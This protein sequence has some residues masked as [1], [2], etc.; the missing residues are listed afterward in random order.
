MYSLANKIVLVTGASSGIGRAC[1]GQCAAQGADPMLCAR[2]LDRLRDLAE[3]HRRDY[4]V[5]VNNAGV[6]LHLD[7]VQTAQ[8]SDWDKMIEQEITI[9]RE[10]KC[11]G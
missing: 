1:A 4:G 3:A 7:K 5:R 11:A 8:I 9:R 10:P 2:R 6:S